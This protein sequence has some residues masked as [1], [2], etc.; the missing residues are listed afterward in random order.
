M[1]TQRSYL[2]T[3]EG[4]ECCRAAGFQ[5][6]QQGKGL[7]NECQHGGAWDTGVLYFANHK[8][9]SLPSTATI[10]LRCGAYKASRP[11]SRPSHATVGS[12]AVSL[13]E[14]VPPISRTPP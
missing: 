6:S 4:L 14:G 2:S 8:Y 5:R 13:Q 10:S 1:Q 12:S 9:L 3:S 11:P 7:F